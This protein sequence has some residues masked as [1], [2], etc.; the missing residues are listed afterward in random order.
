[1]SPPI[2]DEVIRLLRSLFEERWLFA[3][4][5][6]QDHRPATLKQIADS[7]EV[8]VVPD[9]FPLLAAD[10]CVASHVAQAIA[11]LVREATPVQISWLDERLRSASYAYY[12]GPWQKRVPGAAGARQM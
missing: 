4:V 7:R 5:R 12:R 2:S 8:R 11:E 6:R 1:M 9:L 10:D 3:R